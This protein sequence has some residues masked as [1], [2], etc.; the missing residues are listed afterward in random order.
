MRVDSVHCKATFYTVK[1]PCILFCQVTLMK[2]SQIRQKFLFDNN[3]LFYRFTE[4]SVQPQGTHHLAIISNLYSP[5]P[6]LLP[7]TTIKHPNKYMN[8][9]LQITVDCISAV[10]SYSHT[11]NRA[12]QV[13]LV[14]GSS[15]GNPN[16]SIGI[17]QTGQHSRHCSQLSQRP[18]PKGKQNHLPRIACRHFLL[19]L[20][21]FTVSLFLC[22]NTPW[23]AK[24]RFSWHVKAYPVVSGISLRNCRISEGNYT[25]FKLTMNKFQQSFIYK[26]AFTQTILWSYILI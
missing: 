23:G 17:Y 14:Y 11:L 19:L 16:P 18:L 5:V 12:L 1:Q 4:Y 22:L 9:T 6:T 15:E 7:L 26:I 2:I 25:E 21:S 8:K 10:I 20:F 13:C 24:R 3:Y